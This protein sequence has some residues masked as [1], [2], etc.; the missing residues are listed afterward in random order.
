MIEE[1]MNLSDRL[2]NIEKRVESLEKALLKKSF[3]RSRDDR[4]EEFVR[5]MKVQERNQKVNLQ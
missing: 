5:I 4:W 3:K 2:K 1:S